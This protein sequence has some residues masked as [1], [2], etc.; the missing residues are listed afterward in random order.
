MNFELSDNVKFWLTI[1]GYVG[2]CMA[3][4]YVMYKW[5]AG[6]VGAAVAKE[7]IKAGVIMVA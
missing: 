7:L 2:G 4:S 3:I 6:M 5:F 1:I